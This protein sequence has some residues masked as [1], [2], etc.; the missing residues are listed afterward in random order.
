MNCHAELPSDLWHTVQYIAAVW[1]TS[2][3]TTQ[4]NCCFQHI[5][6]ERQIS[7]ALVQLSTEFR[8]KQDSFDTQITIMI[9]FATYQIMQAGWMI[10]QP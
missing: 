4:V 5:C 2:S 10:L 7:N 6:S 9:C 8:R 1:P 3:N